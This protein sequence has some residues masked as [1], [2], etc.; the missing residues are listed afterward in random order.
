MISWRIRSTGKEKKE[1]AELAHRQSQTFW[2][3]PAPS[4][5]LTADTVLVAANISNGI[6]RDAHVWSVCAME[7]MDSSRKNSIW[8]EKKAI[9]KLEPGGMGCRTALM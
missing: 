3:H 2:G 7:L 1:E 6:T 9:W 4:N 5:G 8:T